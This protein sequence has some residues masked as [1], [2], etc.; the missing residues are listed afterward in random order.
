MSRLKEPGKCHLRATERSHFRKLREVVYILCYF[1]FPLQLDDF[2]KISL[3]YFLFELQSMWQEGI[4]NLPFSIPF[5][6]IF[7]R[8]NCTSIHGWQFITLSTDPLDRQAVSD[9]NFTFTWWDLQVSSVKLRPLPIYANVMSDV[10]K[11]EANLQSSDAKTPHWIWCHVWAANKYW[12][13]NI[14]FSFSVWS[15]PLIIKTSYYRPVLCFLKYYS[16]FRL[17]HSLFCFTQ[18]M[19]SFIKTVCSFQDVRVLLRL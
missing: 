4:M 1:L 2:H 12:S 13:L 19:T 15:R 14:F 8:I 5:T 3:W 16:F 9:F 6:I 10:S 7:T 17:H 18:M 11:H